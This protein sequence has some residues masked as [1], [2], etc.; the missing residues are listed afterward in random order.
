ME[1]AEQEPEWDDETADE[2]AAPRIDQDAG[3]GGSA[4][5]RW[6]LPALAGVLVLAVAA[7]LGALLLRP[8][9]QDLARQFQK[10]QLVPFS[11]RYPDAWGARTESIHLLVSADP[12]ALGRLFLGGGSGDW[13]AT[14]RLLNTDAAKA[15]GMY[16]TFST[17]LSDPTNIEDIKTL[18]PAGAEF[19][20][21]VRDATIGGLPGK[22]VDGTLTDPAS[23]SQLDLVT[24]AVKVQSP[25]PELVVLAFFS[26]PTEKSANTDTFDRMVDTVDFG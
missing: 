26:A 20:G 22:V 4:L 6:M 7:T 23:G 17:S 8:A 2:D 13:S 21:A 10:S 16:T 11:F 1:G 18:L 5:Q 15:V 14:R 3:R 24:Y 19:P 12:D 9:R 25:Q